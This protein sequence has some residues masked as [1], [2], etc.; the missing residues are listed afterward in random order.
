MKSLPT[1]LETAKKQAKLFGWHFTLVDNTLKMDAHLYGLVKIT[2]PS[3]APCVRP[4]D[5]SAYSVNVPGCKNSEISWN[6][7]YCFGL[8]FN[9]SILKLDD[10]DKAIEVYRHVWSPYWHEVKFTPTG[11]YAGI[12]FNKWFSHAPK[13]LCLSKTRLSLNKVFSKPLPLP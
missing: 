2:Q 9:A 4:G 11:I 7:G 10:L 13:D 8:E 3:I 5:L 6:N 12:Q 1:W